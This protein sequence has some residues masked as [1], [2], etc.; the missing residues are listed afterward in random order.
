MTSASAILRDDVKTEPMDT[1]INLTA[2]TQEGSNMWVK[3]K[4]ISL[5]NNDKNLLVHGKKL[6]DKHMNLAHR[7]LKLNFPNINGLRLTLLQDKAHKEPT[8]NALQI[9]HTGGDHWVCA[10]TIGTSGKK[11]WYMTQHILGGIMQQFICLK[12]SFDVQQA[13]LPS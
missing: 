7:I 5:T 1:D 10:T 11:C 8:D 6:T 13:I 3:V 2:E 12:D 4:D 9:F